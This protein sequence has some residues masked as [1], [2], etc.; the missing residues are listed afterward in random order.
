MSSFASR[1]PHIVDVNRPDG[2]P[3]HSR[4]I[5]TDDP[6]EVTVSTARRAH[7]T[8]SVQIR[9]SQSASIERSAQLRTRREVPHRTSKTDSRLTQNARFPILERSHT[10]VYARLAPTAL[11]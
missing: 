5:A 6:A 2:S 11:Y 8:P 10:T 1:S 9:M 7:Y 4:S 3:R